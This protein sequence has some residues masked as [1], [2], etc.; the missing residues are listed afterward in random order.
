M[1]AV[2]KF[3]ISPAEPLEVK[4][5]RESVV[6]EVDV[7]DVRTIDSPARSLQRRLDAAYVAETPHEATKWPVHRRAAFILGAGALGWAVV[8]AA[9]LIL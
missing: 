5:D 3:S 9:I 7:G 1:K 8:L 4:L 2:R 6:A